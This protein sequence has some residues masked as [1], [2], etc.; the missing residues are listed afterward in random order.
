MGPQRTRVSYAVAATGP[1]VSEI[2]PVIASDFPDVLA[3]LA[4]RAEASMSGMSPG[5]PAA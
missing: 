2:G 4:A 5:A 3:E 1:E